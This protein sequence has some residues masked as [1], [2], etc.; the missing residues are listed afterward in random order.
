MSQT[1][2]IV[3]RM[4]TLMSRIVAI[5]F[6]FVYIFYGGMQ[7]GQSLV[8][9]PVGK[10]MNFLCFDE[11]TKIQTAR[12]KFPMKD[13]RLGDILMENNA[14]VT[15]I[16]KLDGSGI[17]MYKIKDILVTG[18]HKMAY[19][20]RFV[21]VDK[22]P[23]AEKVDT[24]CN[25]LVCFNTSNNRIRID[26]FDF[27]DF[28]ETCTLELL[29][30]KNEY[31]QHMY[32][33]SSNHEIHSNRTGLLPETRIPIED[34][35]APVNM[36]KVGQVLD[37]GNVV[38]AVVAHLVPGDMPYVE[39]G[40]GIITSPSTWVYKNDKIRRAYEVGHMCLDVTQHPKVFYQLI[41][42]E[43]IYPITNASG[44]RIF[45]LDELETTD[46]YYHK[47]KDTIISSGRFPIKRVV[48]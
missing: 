44:D 21:R 16:Y 43:S 1:Q 47:L 5:M 15:S 6:S 10:T 14:T 13:V 45:V 3:I 32:N 2:Y 9:G 48:V 33:G 40:S 20:G 11:N 17:Q 31:I 25:N 8:N 28:E 42:E 4:R 36:V 30:F 46:P 12:G 19:K 38:K 37:N 24:K 27:L 29:R 7:S 18:S 41:T 22:H 35:F 39:V 34:G 23:L 26:G